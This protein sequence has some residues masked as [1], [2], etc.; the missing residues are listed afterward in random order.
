MVDDGALSPVAA[1]GRAGVNALLA[2]A[3]ESAGA[4]GAE[5]ALGAAADLGV[6]EVALPTLA[7]VAVAVL[8]AVAIGAAGVRHAGVLGRRGRLG[9][10][11]NGRRRALRVHRRRDDRLVLD[12]RGRPGNRRHGRGGSWCVGRDGRP[13]HGRRRG[14]GDRRGRAPDEGIACEAAEAAAD[15]VVVDDAALGVDAAR[16]LAGV[17]AAV[18]EAGEQRRAL[19]VHHAL[20]AARGRVAHEAGQAGAHPLQVDL[21]TGGVR[22]ARVARTRVSWRLGL[23]HS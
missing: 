12:R 14:L 5:D 11:H 1:C 15:W 19:G 7:H 4:V 23:R 10:V 8:T 22:A 20:W 6:A 18:V 13:H 3:R 21:A 9:E 2:D 16:A 17:H